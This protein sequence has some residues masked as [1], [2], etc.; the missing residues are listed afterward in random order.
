VQDAEGKYQR[1]GRTGALPGAAVGLG[2]RNGHGL[3]P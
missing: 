2:E 1:R 3:Y